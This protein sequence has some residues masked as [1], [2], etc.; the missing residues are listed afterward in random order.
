MSFYSLLGI[1]KVLETN[2][3]DKKRSIRIH[4]HLIVRVKGIRREY[5]FRTGMFIHKFSELGLGIDT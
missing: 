1:N 2:I 3:E 4:A 5:G